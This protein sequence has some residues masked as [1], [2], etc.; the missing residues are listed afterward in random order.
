MKA[1][2]ES[3]GIAAVFEQRYS[4]ALFLDLGTRRG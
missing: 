2:R 4:S 1:L 3:R